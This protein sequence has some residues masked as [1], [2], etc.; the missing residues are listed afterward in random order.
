MSDAFAAFFWEMVHGP[1]GAALA[2]VGASALVLS[3][4]SFFH[5]LTGSSSSDE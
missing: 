5:N 2:V 1:V 4:V 3:F